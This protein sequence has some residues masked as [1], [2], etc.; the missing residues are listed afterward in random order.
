MARHTKKGNQNNDGGFL[1]RWSARKNQIAKSDVVTNEESLELIEGTDELNAAEDES[2]GLTDSELLKKYEL[3]DPEGVTDETGLSR[4]LDSDIPERLRQMALRRIWHLNPSFGVVCDMVE[5][6][7]DYTDAATVIE[8]MQTAYQ[9]GKGYET[10]AEV[11]T[12]PD[13]NEAD[14]NE[15]GENEA[16]ENEAGENE[17]GENEAVENEAG[18]NE[19]GENEAGENEAGEKLWDVS[20]DSDDHKVAFAE[21]SPVDLD[22]YILPSNAPLLPTA[23]VVADKRNDLSASASR[24]N[25]DVSLEVGAASKVEPAAGGDDE[26]EVFQIRSQTNRT[27]LD[28]PSRMT[29]TNSTVKN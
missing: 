12:P 23:D 19:A 8:G 10:K 17:A 28:R 21:L 11:P 16:G 20:L 9:V 29:F 7:E 24:E 15:A 2:A 1:S 18:E 27:S 25:E 22:K 3:P 6:G 5:Y 4:F 14:E 26:T 13:E